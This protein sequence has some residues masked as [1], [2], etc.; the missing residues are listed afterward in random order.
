MTDSNS[1]LPDP[2]THYLIRDTVDSD[3]R[4]EIYHIPSLTTADSLDA[5]DAERQ[6]HPICRPYSDSSRAD[7]YDPISRDDPPDNAR[8]C[9]KCERL[10]EMVEGYDFRI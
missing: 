9:L 2:K 3:D 10:V 6:L 5:T 7:S 8:L 4:P 1:D